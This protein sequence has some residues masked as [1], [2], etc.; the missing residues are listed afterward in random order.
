LQTVPVQIHPPVPKGHAGSGH[1][2]RGFPAGV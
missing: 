1:A 2:F